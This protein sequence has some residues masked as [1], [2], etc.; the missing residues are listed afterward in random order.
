MGKKESAVPV[1][2]ELVQ[3][4][5]H[6]KQPNCFKLVDKAKKKKRTFTSRARNELTLR[7]GQ[8]LT[9][10]FGRVRPAHAAST[11]VL[12]VGE[13]PKFLISHAV[14]LDPQAR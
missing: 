11:Q 12:L 14:H 4:D 2:L 9:Y 10:S 7:T 8:G 6:A 1:Q 3:G 5:K 13:A